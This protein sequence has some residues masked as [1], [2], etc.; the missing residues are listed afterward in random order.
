MNPLQADGPL[1]AP[2]RLGN[3]EPEWLAWRHRLLDQ[4]QA[5]NLLKLAHG[6]RGLGRDGAEPIGEFLEGLDFLLL[7]LVGR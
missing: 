6:L 7:V 5:F 2:R 4:L 1:A 3:L